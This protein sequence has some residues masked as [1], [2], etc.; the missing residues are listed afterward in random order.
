MMASRFHYEPM[1]VGEILMIVRK[2]DTATLDPVPEM[3][4]IGCAKLTDVDRTQNV[5]AIRLQQTD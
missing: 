2:Q 5:V 1:Q 3:C 4:C